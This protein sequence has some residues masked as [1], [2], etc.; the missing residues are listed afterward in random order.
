MF[1]YVLKNL[2]IFYDYYIWLG[3]SINIVVGE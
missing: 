2:A 1:A 3:G